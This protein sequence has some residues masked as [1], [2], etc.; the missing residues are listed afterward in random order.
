MSGPLGIAILGATGS[1]GRSTLAVIALHPERFRVAVL[2]AYGSWQTVVEQ[3]KKF[4]PDGHRG[5]RG[6]AL[7]PRRRACG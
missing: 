2:A 4:Q 6:I 3:A 7:D 1:V 5:C